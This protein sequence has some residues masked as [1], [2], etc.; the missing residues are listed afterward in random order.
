M[1]AFIKR[2][3][4]GIMATGLWALAACSPAAR[5]PSEDPDPSAIYDSPGSMKDFVDRSDVIFQGTVLERTFLGLTTR[6]YSGPGHT[7]IIEAPD[8]ASVRETPFVEVTAL[9]E[10]GQSETLR[11]RNSSRPWTPYTAYRLR[12]NRVYKAIPSVAAEQEVVLHAVGALDGGGRH[13]GPTP[14]MAEGSQYLFAL[15][16]APDQVNFSQHFAGASRLALG[17][18][19]DP[20]DDTVSE[21]WNRPTPV[22]F[23]SATRVDAFVAELKAALAP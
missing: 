17:G 10:A 19:P 16:R 13:G 20:G 11:L 7:L 18:Y 9:S 22:R 12:V 3:T 8:A 1:A 15:V 23:T 6:N 5:M 4:R 14:P 21:M 2:P